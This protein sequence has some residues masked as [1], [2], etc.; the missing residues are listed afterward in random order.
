[1]GDFIIYVREKNMKNTDLT[2]LHKEIENRISQMESESYEFPRRFSRGD[3][4]F[5]AVVAVICLAAI[6]GGAFIA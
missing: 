6:I 1:M 2:E 5:T 3:Y 4:I